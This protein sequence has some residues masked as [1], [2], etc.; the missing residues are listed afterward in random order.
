M[1]R[2]SLSSLLSAKDPRPISSYFIYFAPSRY[3]LRDKASTGK[4]HPARY[5][6]VKTSSSSLHRAQ[7]LYRRIFLSFLR[8]DA[9]GNGDAKSKAI[10]AGKDVAN[11]S[12]ALQSYF[13]AFPSPSVP[14]ASFGWAILLRATSRLRLAKRFY[15]LCQSRNARSYPLSLP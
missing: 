10:G 4:K 3:A 2:P 8:G 1:C 11:S 13:T 5:A 6:R 15:S 14:C 9:V 7:R 12:V